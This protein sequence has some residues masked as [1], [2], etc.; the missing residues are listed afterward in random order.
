[1]GTGEHSA[2]V[3]ST[4]SKTFWWITALYTYTEQQ[5]TQRYI[6]LLIGKT[7]GVCMLRI[8]GYITHIIYYYY[9]HVLLYSDY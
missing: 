9:C 7:V 3:K 6:R 4:Q 5:L 1:M 8:F 2:L